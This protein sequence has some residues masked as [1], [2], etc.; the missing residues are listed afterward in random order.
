[1]KFLLKLFL[2]FALVVVGGA[3]FYGRSLPREHVVTSSIVLVAPADTVFKV[4]RNIEASP[5]WWGDVKTV[6]RLRGQSGEVWREDMGQG[7]VIDV[8]IKN[9]VPG[10][11]MEMHILGGE[12]QG[13]GGV[14]YYEVINSPSG[15]E[16]LLTEEGWVEPPLFRALMKL[17][18]TYRTI[19]S[20]LSSLGAHFG[21]VATPRHG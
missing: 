16:V 14:W 6:E 11:T 1:M 5:T 13:W 17:R 7:G 21:E 9:V 8:A 12:Q 3:Y 4:I 19:D 20:Y 18:G 15:T 2:V 10:R